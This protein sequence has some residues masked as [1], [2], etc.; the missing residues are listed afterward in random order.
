MTVNTALP[1]LSKVAGAV[2]EILL[3]SEIDAAVPGLPP[4]TVTLAVS[5][6]T[7]SDLS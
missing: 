3:A 6:P 1:E 5:S 7:I 2:P 4:E